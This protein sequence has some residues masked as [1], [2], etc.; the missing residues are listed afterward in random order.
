MYKI[1]S[2]Q[3]SRKKKNEDERRKKEHEAERTKRIARERDDRINRYKGRPELK[4]KGLERAP[5]KEP[6]NEAETALLLQAMISSNH[7][8]IDFLI[9]DYNTSR[10]VDMVIEATDKQIPS[11]KWAEIVF[12]LDNLFKWRHPPEGYHLVVCYELGGIKEKQAFENGL[13]AQLI[14][15]SVPGR[16]A[17]LVG[18][19]S[20]DVYV[21]R[22]IL[23]YSE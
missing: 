11:I 9:G 15:K 18:D 1:I 2:A 10:G 21:L 6:N 17:M 22:E 5:I 8:G 3:R 23:Q 4:F 12:S 7:P 16:Y 14:P 19:E 20:L 13:E